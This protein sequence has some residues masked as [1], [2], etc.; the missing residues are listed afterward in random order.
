ML[1]SDGILKN[2]WFSNSK[3]GM[4][5]E[6]RLQRLLKQNFGPHPK[7]FWFNG[8]RWGLQIP[9]WCWCCWSRNPTLTVDSIY[10]TNKKAKA[11]NL[12]SDSSTATGLVSGKHASNH[13]CMVGAWRRRCSTVVATNKVWQS[14]NSRSWSDERME[15]QIYREHIAKELESWS[16]TLSEV[17]RK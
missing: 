4:N 9:S 17:A 10:F 13:M 15:C 11:W 2:T 8:Y 5:F 7:R 6:I 3:F 12:L 1:A 16:Q 14:G